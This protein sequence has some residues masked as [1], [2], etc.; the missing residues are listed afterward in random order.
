M[1]PKICAAITAET[2]DGSIKM[3]QKAEQDGADLLELRA[4]Y[5]KERE[6]LQD[7]LGSSSLPAILTV[8]RPEEGGV[9]EGNED[10]RIAALLKWSGEGFEYVDVELSTLGFSSLIDDLRRTGVKAIVSHHDMRST[11]EVSKIL[12]MVDAE[13]QCG[14]DICKIVTRAKDEM[15]NLPCLT[16]VVEASKRTEIVCFAAGEA[17]R[18]S[19]VLS[20]LLGARFTFASVTRGSESAPGQLTVRELRTIYKTLGYL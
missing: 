13:I 16:A 5:L 15:D 10:E 12:R 4:D 18:I 19:R 20:P 14:A 7:F 11:P 3:G 9:F 17:G 6:N 8:R 2:I 1:K